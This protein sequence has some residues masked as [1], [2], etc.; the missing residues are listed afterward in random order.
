M[1]SRLARSLHRRYPG[2]RL[3][4][5]AREDHRVILYLIT[6]V[7]RLPDVPLLEIFE[8]QV[9]TRHGSPGPS[10]RVP[11]VGAGPIV[12]VPDDGNEVRRLVDDHAALALTGSMS[13]AQAT[14]E[15]VP[16]RP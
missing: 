3:I 12:P 10:V 1:A 13:H 4:P 8:P 14:V 11:G 7:A 2:E 6:A 9:L 5:R 15:C 16:R